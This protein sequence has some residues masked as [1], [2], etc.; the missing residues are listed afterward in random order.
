MFK[1]AV[2]RLIGGDDS[3]MCVCAVCVS[4]CIVIAVSCPLVSNSLQYSTIYCSEQQNTTTHTVFGL[5]SPSQSTRSKA[6][7][8]IAVI[9]SNKGNLTV[10]QTQPAELNGQIKLAAWILK[11]GRYS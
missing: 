10:S 6:R 4:E 8:G 5:G 1:W 2:K 7:E 11:R 3:S 9:S